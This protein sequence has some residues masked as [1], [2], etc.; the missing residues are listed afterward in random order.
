MIIEAL[1]G[2]LLHKTDFLVVLPRY[3]CLHPLY[4]GINKIS[5]KQYQNIYHHEN[6]KEYLIETQCFNDM[7]DLYAKSTAKQKK[8]R[9][10]KLNTY[11]N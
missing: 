3:T 2:R 5:I 9:R 8:G 7:I 10:K 4:T 6:T 1:C 11:N